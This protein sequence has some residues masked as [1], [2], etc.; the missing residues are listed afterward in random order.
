YA[1]KEVGGAKVAFIG[2]TLEGTPS[3]TDA[4]AIEGLSFAN[5]VKTANALVPELKKQGAH[6][7]VMLLHQGAFQDTTGTYDTCA[8]LTGDLLPSLHGDPDAGTPVL[9]PAVDVV[10]SAHTHQP[11]DCVIDERL[12]TSAASFGRIVTKIDLKIDTAA[13]KVVGKKAHNIPVT[14]DVAPD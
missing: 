9:D 2:L 14:R 7:I 1:I 10:V 8:G 13:G 12:V 11:Y 4:T 5:E 6:A 3:V